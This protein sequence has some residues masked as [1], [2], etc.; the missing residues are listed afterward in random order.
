[1]KKYTD[2]LIV[3]GGSSGFGAAYR[4]LRHGKYTVTLVEPNPGLGGTSTYG[5][6]NCWEPG[7]GGQG[8]H[9]LLAERLQA[10]GAGFVGKTYVFA[11]DETPWGRS[12]PCSDQ[13]EE[14]LIR[15]FRTG[16]EQRR[17]HF[18]PDAMAKT[19]LNLLHSV[20]ANQKATYLFHSKVT[21]AAT[22]GRQ[23]TAVTVET[24][25]GSCT[26]VPKLVLDCTGDLIVARPAG[27]ACAFGEDSRSVYGEPN[28][29]DSAQ[30]IVNG[31]TL[32]FRVTPCA[33]DYVE[34]I[35]EEYADVDLS[36]W[37]NELNRTNRPLSCFNDYPNGDININMLPTLPGEYWLNHSLEEV[38]HICKARIYAYWNWIQ[39]KKR[40]TGYRI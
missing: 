27:C 35:P 15:S 29:P 14:T 18:E 33:P 9:H 11:S 16:T 8:V 34:E 39:T 28:A 2:I 31:L 32:A 19:M 40:V 24:P 38:M 37:L 25:E 10:K 13:Y 12:G 4:I 5:G 1:M 20:D 3:G 7:Y 26:I 23:L 30:P 17:F 21:A 36:D 22:D 6:I